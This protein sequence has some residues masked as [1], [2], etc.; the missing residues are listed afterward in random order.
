MQHNR[1]DVLTLGMH[2]DGVLVDTDVHVDVAAH[3]RLQTLGAGAEI[4]DLHVKPFFLEEA[5]GSGHVHRHERDLGRG[6]A[7]ANFCLEGAA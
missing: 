3:Q 2:A 4:D 5:L 1:A 6:S 7:H